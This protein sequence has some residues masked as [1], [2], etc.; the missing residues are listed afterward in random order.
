[1]KQKRAFSASVLTPY[2]FLAPYLVLFCGFVLIPAIF[3]LWISLHNWNYLLPNQ[4]F[5]GLQNYTDLFKEGSVTSG[6]FWQ[7]MLNT[8]IFTVLSVPFLLIIPL[9]VAVVL[10][11]KFPGQ[12]VFRALYFAPYVLGVAVIGILWRYILDPN[13]GLLNFYLGKLGL[14]NSTPWTTATPWAWFSLVGVTV[15]WTL[16]FNTVI[17]MAGLQNIDKVLYEAAKVDGANGWLR[18]LNITLPGLRPVALF[19]LTITILSSANVF[20]QPFII[21]QGAP[22]NDTRSAIMYI[23]NEGLRSYRMGSAAAMSYILAIFLALIS[24]VNFK[25]FSYK[26]D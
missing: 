4:T 2:L 11:Q 22:G 25:F 18:F 24:I 8:L 14:S 15:W 3:G 21:T 20:G 26:G 1:M 9:I 17:Y 5:V 13:F 10:N 12:K 6:F 19:V 7:S 16:G 23:S